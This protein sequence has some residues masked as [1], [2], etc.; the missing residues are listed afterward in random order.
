MT[1]PQYVRAERIF[2]SHHAV[3]NEKWVQQQI[4]ADPTLLGIGE[5][6]VK[7]LERMQPRAGRLDML[8]QD[9]ETY[10]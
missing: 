3:Y 4:A 1:T 9:P 2:L 5:L 8:L 6:E 7:D 10:R